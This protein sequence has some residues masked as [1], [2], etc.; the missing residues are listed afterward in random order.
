VIS[1]Q[2]YRIVFLTFSLLGQMKRRASSDASQ[3]EDAYTMIQAEYNKCVKQMMAAQQVI[4]DAVIWQTRP[5]YD[6]ETQPKPDLHVATADL[7][8]CAA[9]LEDIKQRFIHIASNIVE[10]NI[11]GD[12]YVISF[13][14]NNTLQWKTSMT[15]KI[16]EHT[17]PACKVTCFR[18]RSPP[19]CFLEIDWGYIDHAGLKTTH[20]LNIEEYKWY[21]FW[22]KFTTR[23][24]QR[25][26]Q[27][28]TSQIALFLPDTLSGQVGSYVCYSCI[29]MLTFLHE[30]IGFC[31]V[32]NNEMREVCMLRINLI[33]HKE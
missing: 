25:R 30:Y 26:I 24:S 11:C 22:A 28:A 27:Q 29:E 18:I 16:E 32:K 9:R 15:K 12:V 8:A 17:T 14:K 19:G 10:F 13:A 23:E 5:F 4:M 6:P 31:T 1:Q 20:S 3:T 7:C 33:L 2:Q 21:Q